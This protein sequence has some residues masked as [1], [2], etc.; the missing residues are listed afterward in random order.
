M[1]KDL[2][3]NIIKIEKDK[4]METIERTKT[5]PTWANYLAMDQNG[6]INC[7][8]HKTLC[9]SVNDWGFPLSAPDFLYI[10][11]NMK[12]YCENWRLSLRKIIGVK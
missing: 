8:S 10:P 6:I 7:Y 2:V 5:I 4:K 12:P 1:I 11:I 9:Q 3:M